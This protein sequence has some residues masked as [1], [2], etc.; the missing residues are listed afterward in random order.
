MSGQ[1]R[2]EAVRCI[3]KERL[4]GGETTLVLGEKVAFKLTWG[5]GGGGSPCAPCWQSLAQSP[6][7]SRRHQ[8][9]GQ[10]TVGLWLRDSTADWNGV[11][12][13]VQMVGTPS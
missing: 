3:W 10:R 5:P 8:R 12:R 7:G 6:Q 11:I 9:A 1:E 2:A 4:S 13:I